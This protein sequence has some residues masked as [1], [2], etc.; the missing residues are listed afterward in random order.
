[1]AES[2]RTSSYRAS[3]AAGDAEDGRW[4]LPQTAMFVALSS[5]GLWTLIV[6]GA[7]WLLG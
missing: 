1:M 2:I 3:P 6:A 5:V 7:R 4:S